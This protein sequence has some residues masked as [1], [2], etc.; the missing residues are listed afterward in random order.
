M[1]KLSKLKEMEQSQGK[2]IREILTELYMEYGSQT[3]VAKALGIS[4]STLSVWL[5]KSG[6]QEQTIIVERHEARQ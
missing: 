6:L 2:S 1:A 5:L 4:Q 3:K